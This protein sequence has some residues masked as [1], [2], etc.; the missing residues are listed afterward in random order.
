MP[1]PSRNLNCVGQ[2]AR[3]QH[4]LRDASSC[5]CRACS[6][7]AYSSHSRPISSSD[8][9]RYWRPLSVSF[10]FRVDPVRAASL[11]HALPC[12]CAPRR[13]PSRRRGCCWWPPLA[14]SRR[15]IS[16]RIDDAE[17]CSTVL[18][19]ADQ[20]R[21]HL[22]Q[23]HAARHS[24][25]DIGG[26]LHFAP[27]AARLAVGCS[28]L[29]SAARFLLPRLPRQQRSAFGF[30][31][32][33]DCWALSLGFRSWCFRSLERMNVASGSAPCERIAAL[34]CCRVPAPMSA[35]MVTKD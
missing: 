10:E 17:A 18:S 2:R 3:V 31:S 16:S 4:A 6:R 13:R 5:P 22:R 20:V 35:G 1:G 12:A 24:V 23:R 32:C 30:A 19:S 26:A 14:W 15:A 11:S 33:V 34:N 21:G 8:M 27:S 28:A 25:G 29:S 7:R 9:P